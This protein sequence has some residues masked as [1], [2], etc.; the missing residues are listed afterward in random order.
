MVD[1]EEKDKLAHI[2]IES[3]KIQNERRY[4]YSNIAYSV[5]FRMYKIIKHLGLTMNIL[6]FYNHS[7]KTRNL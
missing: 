4:Y 1:T 7:Y 6:P 5:A 3:D 2:D